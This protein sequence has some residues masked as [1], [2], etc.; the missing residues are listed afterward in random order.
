M[1]MSPVRLGTKNRCASEDRQRFSTQLTVSCESRVRSQRLEL[2]VTSPKSIVRCHYQATTNED[3][4]DLVFE[5]AEY[6]DQ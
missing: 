3:I 2:A 1:V 5:V 4:E 6:L